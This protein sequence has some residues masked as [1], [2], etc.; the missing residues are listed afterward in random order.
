MD[1]QLSLS[2]VPACALVEEFLFKE[3]GPLI[4]SGLQPVEESEGGMKRPNKLH[5]VDGDIDL[6]LAGVLSASLPFPLLY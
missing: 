2:A 3:L 6:I 4:E 5:K 1:Q